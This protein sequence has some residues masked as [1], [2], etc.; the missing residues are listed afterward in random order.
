MNTSQIK[1]ILFAN[2]VSTKKK[3]CSCSH[4]GC[5]CVSFAPCVKP[6][7]KK[8]SIFERNENANQTPSCRPVLSVSITI[9]HSTSAK[10]AHNQC[11]CDCY[12]SLH[13]AISITHYKE[14]PPTSPPPPLLCSLLMSTP[15]STIDFCHDRSGPRFPFIRLF[16]SFPHCPPKRHL[17]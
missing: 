6:H 4:T 16:S 10:T 9:L 1:F 2:L 11:R 5:D 8:E 7:K 3:L 15:R 17:F 12:K 14:I 13:Q